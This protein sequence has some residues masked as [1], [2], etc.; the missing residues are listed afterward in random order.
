MTMTD[1]HVHTTL[2]DGA[3]TPAE[4]AETAFKKGFTAL[5]F[6]GH[7]Y[8][9]YDDYCMTKE[10]TAVYNAQIKHLKT[11][12][13]GK[14]EIFCGIEQDYFSDMPTDGYDYVIGSLH[15]LSKEASTSVDS[16]AEITKTLVETRFHGD[17]AKYAEEYYRLEADVVK[18]T[19]CDII[20]HFDLVTKYNEV[21]GY[22]ETDAYFTHAFSALDELLKFDRIFEL[23]VGA[24]TRKYRKT[25]YPSVPIL[26]RMCEKKAKIILN[27]DC[28]NKLFL[29]DHLEDIKELA[30]SCGFKSR[31][32][33]TAQGFKEIEL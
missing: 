3:S 32:I 12:Y 33:F 18:K 28:H 13:K 10:N 25:P 31:F 30:K 22:E 19:D 7:S 1:F 20:G 26:K 5:G 16:S 15:S 23:N 11:Q 9:D 21:L 4:M 29:G 2:C 14:M 24:M 27:G 6:S 8:I 17:F